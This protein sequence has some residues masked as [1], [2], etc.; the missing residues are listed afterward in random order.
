MKKCILGVAMVAL[1]TL[2]A[3]AQGWSGSY[4]GV[5][6]GYGWGHSDQ[7][8]PGLI[9][10][11]AP[12]NFGD[13]HFPVNGGV[14]GGT[15]GRNLQNGRWVYGVESDLSW[16]DIAG[17][18]PVCGQTTPTPQPCGTKL[19]ALGTFRGRAGYAAGANADWLLYATG[20]LAIG[21]VKG[22]DLSLIHISEPTRL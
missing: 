1:G 5:S 18:S 17:Q 6:G 20:G 13:G 8:D 11:P 9:N 19:E 3:A 2:P 14:F 21:E 4:G 22:W 15:L 7:T 16:A 12:Q 10:I